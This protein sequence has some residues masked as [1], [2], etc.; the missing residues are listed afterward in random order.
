M[1]GLRTS[2]TVL[3]GTRRKHI[4]TV[5]DS[6]TI[7][8]VPFH[9]GS[10]HSLQDKACGAIN[11]HSI[12]TPLAAPCPLHFSITNTVN[13]S[14][15]HSAYYSLFLLVLFV[16]VTMSWSFKGDKSWTPYSAADQ[17]AIEKAHKVHLRTQHGAHRL[18]AG[19]VSPTHVRCLSRRVVISG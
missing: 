5:W 15:A 7:A 3:H 13:H 10:S 17:Q 11:R 6:S 12:P 18:V 2:E 14:L 8:A 19:P 16:T 9:S 4:P 1:F